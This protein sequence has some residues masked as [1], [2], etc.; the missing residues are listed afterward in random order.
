MDV[1]IEQVE[2]GVSIA[3]YLPVSLDYLLYV[4]VYKVVEGIDVLLHHS[5]HLRLL[6]VLFLYTFIHCTSLYNM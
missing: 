1:F 4:Y 3:N 5:F 2:V 6:S